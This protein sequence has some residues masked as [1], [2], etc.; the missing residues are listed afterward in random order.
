MTATDARHGQHV[1]I[2]T[3]P[4]LTD[5]QRANIRAWMDL[6]DVLNEGDFG[7]RMDAF[8]HP[9]MTYGNPSRPD[10]GGYATWKTSPE[11]MYARFKAFQ[12]VRSATGLGDDQ[13]WTHNRQ[14][15]QHTGGRY[16]GVEPTGHDITVEWFSVVTFQD[17]KI[18]RI[19]SIADVLGMLMQVGVLPRT[20]LPVDPYK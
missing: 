7:E 12:W 10:L 5:R 2:D 6:Q 18:I 11:Q 17:G 4:G 19:F 3:L 1:D 16:M 20:A 8:F 14:V 15:G 13:I 9:D